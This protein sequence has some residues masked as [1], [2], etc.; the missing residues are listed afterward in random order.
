M[1]TEIQGRPEETY[2][3]VYPTDDR[4][5]LLLNEIKERVAANGMV[6]IP[7]KH[8]EKIRTA[9]ILRCG[10]ECTFLREGDT[11]LVSFYTGSIIYLY[12]NGWLD[13]TR[14]IIREQEAIALIG[15]EQPK[16]EQ[17][18]GE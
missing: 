2:L 1:D 9:K 18:K 13:D 10:P 3:E 15:R 11:I 12:E 14:R 16:I 17:P 7:S 4:V 6:I 5:L 8:A